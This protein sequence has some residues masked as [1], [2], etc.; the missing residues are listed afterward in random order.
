M[1]S[2]PRSTVMGMADSEASNVRAM[3]GSDLVAAYDDALL[4]MARRE[5]GDSSMTLDDAARWYH[6]QRAARGEGP[7][8]LGTITAPTTSG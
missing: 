4:V 5:T 7:S 8:R 2:C 1:V 3:A 6:G